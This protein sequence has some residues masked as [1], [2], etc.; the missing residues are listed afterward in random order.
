[1]ILVDEPRWPAHGTLFGHLVS[2]SSYAELIGFAQRAGLHPR[3][4]DHDHYDVPLRR[5]DELVGLGAEPV[6]STDLIRRLR[7]SGLRVPQ[8]DRTPKRRAVLPRVQRAWH[9]LLPEASGLGEDL[10]R[11]WSEEG[12]HYHDVRHLAQALAA[13]DALG[14]RGRPVRLAAWFHDAVYA[15]TASDEHDSADLAAAEL[16]PLIGSGEADEVAR[17]VRLTASHDPD[18]GDRDGAA[19]VDAD[20][21]ILG[22]RTGRYLVYA[23]D[24]RLDY[25][26]VPDP[27]FRAGRLE[28]LHRLLGRPSVYVSDAARHRWEDA[29]RANLA[30]EADHLE[31]A[32]MLFPLG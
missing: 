9:E 17:L 8:R 18:P 23:R 30:W 28:V 2:D 26:P 6:E 27:Q 20:L 24:V 3:A 32:G 11:R 15:G 10:L 13:L 31:S 7:T 29:A 1:M 16:G 4:F 19:L 5:H 14:A 22:Q 25:A 12:R 21:S